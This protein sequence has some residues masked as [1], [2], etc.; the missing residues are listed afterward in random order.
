ME[1]KVLE[2]ENQS[3]PI[4][5]CDLIRAWTV[6][7]KLVVSLRK[8]GSFYSTP[9]AHTALP[10]DQRQKMLEDLDTYFSPEMVRELSVARR[11]L[12]EYLPDD[13]AEAISERLKFWESKEQ[14]TV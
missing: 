4:A 6:L 10:P 11:V 9:D 5:K 14:Q 3:I 12:G 1:A 2:T 8:M 7:E 13:E